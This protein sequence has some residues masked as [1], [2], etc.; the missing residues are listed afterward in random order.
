MPLLAI[1]INHKTASVHIRERVA[2]APDRLEE[3]HQ[4]CCDLLALDE[5]VILSTCNRTELFVHGAVTV[6]A[7]AQWLAD[8]HGV[9]YQELRDSLYAYSDEAAVTHIMNVACGL[10]SLVLG[11]PQILGQVKSAFAVAKSSNTVSG[12][13]HMLF[14][15]V[16][17]AAKQVRRETA[18]GSNPVSVAYAAV[19]LSKTIFSDLSATSALLIGAGETIDLV[20]QHLH[21]HK[22]KSMVVANRTL[23]R[24]QELAERFDAQAILLSDIAD[25]LPH[26]DI[27]ISSTASQLPILGKGTVETAMAQRRNEPQFMVDIAVPR[28]IEPEVGDL[29]DVYLYTV[30]DLSEVIKDGQRAREQAAHQAAGLMKENVAEYL[31]Q[32]RS[33]NSVATIKAYRDQS[34]QIRDRELARA[35]KLLQSGVSPELALA[36]LARSLTNKL[37]HAPTTALAKAGREGRM[38]LI[39]YGQELLNVDLKEDK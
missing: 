16:F 8:Y 17:S 29:A 24:A 19:R 25:H 10:D 30:D 28:D 35:E 34:E 20:A 37:V 26:A 3:A 38:D 1:G 36:D 32:L 5:V 6:E 31:A 27:I 39:G 11:E 9:D 13:M 14:Q 4:Q 2:F 21:Q 7:I 23:E 15:Q 22:L 33:K 18:I 12:G